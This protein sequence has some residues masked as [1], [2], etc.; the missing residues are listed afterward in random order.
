MVK[1]QAIER[2][3]QKINENSHYMIMDEIVRRESLEY[4][5]TRVLVGEA[6]ENNLTI[7]QIMKSE[8]VV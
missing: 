4:D 8:I 6:E 7:A 1:S 2:G 5:P 3:A